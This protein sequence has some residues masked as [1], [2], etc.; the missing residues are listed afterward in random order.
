MDREEINQDAMF[1]VANRELTDDELSM[2]AEVYSDQQFSDDELARL[3]EMDRYYDAQEDPYADDR[4]TEARHLNRE[5]CSY[6]GF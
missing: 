3:E 6:R 1:D 2:L 5:L 4:N